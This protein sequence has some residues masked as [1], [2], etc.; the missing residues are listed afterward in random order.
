MWLSDWFHNLVSG[1]W[2]LLFCFLWMF[3]GQRR[4]INRIRPSAPKLKI[5]LESSFVLVSAF[6]EELIK[7]GIRL[8][9]RVCVIWYNWNHKIPELE[10]SYKVVS[11]PWIQ[12]KISDLGRI[13]W[14]RFFHPLNANVYDSYHCCRW[15]SNRHWIYF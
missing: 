8:R 3:K 11:R 10:I 15:V 4:R 14:S 9:M 13:P 1:R 7:S 12:G 5:R 6:K 2:R